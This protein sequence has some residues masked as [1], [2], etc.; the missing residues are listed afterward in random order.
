MVNMPLNPNKQTN[1]QVE[2]RIPIK[3]RALLKKINRSDRKRDAKKLRE[4][5]QSFEP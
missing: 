3:K 5:F 2:K 4:T 1:K